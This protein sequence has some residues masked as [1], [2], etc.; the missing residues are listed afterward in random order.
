ML[1]KI[2]IA[3]GI[4]FALA[5]VV[6]G[7]EKTSSYVIGT[8][9]VLNQE[10]DDRA[11]MRLERARIEALIQKERENVL[12]FED[13]VADLE[14]RR[15][16][17]ARGIEEAKKRLEADM[18]LLKRIKAL[19][20]EKRDQYCIGRQTYTYAEVN[21]DA[22]ERVQE[23]ERMQEVV[24]FN[25]SLLAD[26]DAALKQGRSGL[27]ES[28]K[29]L[30]ELKNG[31]ARLEQRNVNAEIR[32][33]VAQLTNAIAGAPLSADSELEKA[34]RNYERRVS[35]KER[36]AT[37]RFLA[38]MGQFRIDYSPAI[39]TQDA[40]VE[41]GRML[42]EAGQERPLPAAP[43]RRPSAVDVIQDEQG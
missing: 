33:Q 12:A 5:V 42:G 28:H 37:T 8:G 7:W 6:L 17:T 16:A 34:V 26:L 11:P 2:I 9:R 21:A 43:Q 14:G 36:S 22:L 18:N 39:V 35:A 13:K 23:V 30:A 1:K 10:A 3:V 15:D 27:G 31:V 20:D 24:A 32:L 40:S 4:L 38:G 41:I 25:D 19:L 29:R